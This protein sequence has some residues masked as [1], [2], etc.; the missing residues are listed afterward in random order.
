[1][2]YKYRHK[3]LAHELCTVGFINRTRIKP[4]QNDAEIWFEFQTALIDITDRHHCHISQHRRS[5][6][7]NRLVEIW[8]SQIVQVYCVQVAGGSDSQ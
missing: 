5:Y 8:N 3:S 7:Q 6:N 2:S 4:N 1:M